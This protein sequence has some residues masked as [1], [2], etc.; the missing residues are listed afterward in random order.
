M[1]LSPIAEV[2]R[3]GSGERWG[4]KAPGRS[5]QRWS[6]QPPR[7]QVHAWLSHVTG[8]SH[9]EFYNKQRA[10]QANLCY[11]ALSLCHLHI[12]IYY[13][14]KDGNT[15]PIFLSCALQLWSTHVLQQLLLS[16]MAAASFCDGHSDFPRVE[17]ETCKCRDSTWSV[18]R[19]HL[20][21]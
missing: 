15:Q 2:W 18:T 6:R 1:I 13:L 19:S 11:G 10:T 7:V 14:E 8:Q 3:D 17:R 21:I 5:R 20:L 4:Q 16:T 12:L 9:T